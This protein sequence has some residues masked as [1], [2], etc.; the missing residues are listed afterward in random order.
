MLI[1]N[2]NSRLNG[3]TMIFQVDALKCDLCGVSV[4]S[5]QIMQTHLAGKAHKR[6][7]AN[8]Q[9]LQS[10]QSSS[11]A[12]AKSFSSS[13]HSSSSR[14]GGNDEKATERSDAEKAALDKEDFAAGQ[15]A[16]VMMMKNTSPRDEQQQPSSSLKCD[17]CNVF[18]NSVQQL[19]VHNAGA[20]HKKAAAKVNNEF[21]VTSDSSNLTFHSLAVE[22]PN[23]IIRVEDP[24][25]K[26]AGS[27]KCKSCDCLLNSEVQM[28][29][30]NL[31]T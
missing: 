16:S 25:K 17:V 30:V 1:V 2:V 13:S 6:R 18:V 12:E 29:Q 8:A 31:V 10:F 15:D 5:D 19:E 23:S 14:N 24:N 9:T 7:L 3:V 27:Y 11:S 26:V 4:Q 28:Q 20:K 21:K 22:L